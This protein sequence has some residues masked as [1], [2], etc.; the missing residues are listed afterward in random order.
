MAAQTPPLSELLLQHRP[1]HALPQPFYND[2]AIFEADLEAF[3]YRDWL[4]AFPACLLEKTGSYQRLKIGAYDVIVLRDGKGEI[5]AFHNTCR[6]RGSVIC[7]AAQGRV[8]KLTCP[9]HQWTY[10]LDGRLLWARDMGPDFDPSKHG[11]KPVHCR[12]M[13]GLVYICL[14]DEAPDFDTFAETV[15][16]Y[17][18]V[19][20]LS[21]AKVAHQSTIIEKGNWKLVWENNRE[22]YHCAGNHPDLCR[23]Y[24][25]DPTISGVSQDGVFP[26]T[27]E[28]HFNRLEQAGAPSRFRLSES[29]EFRVARMPLLDGAE[30]YTINGKIAVQKKLGRIPM[31]D[32]GTLLLFHY[33]TT[34]NHFLSDHSITFRV[35]PIGPQETEVQTTW[36]VNKDAVEGV[37]Y[38]LKN[39]TTVWEHTNDEDRRVV[40]DNQQGINSPAYEPGPYSASHEDGVIQ[41]VSWYLDRMRA[42]HLPDAMAAE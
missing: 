6:H 11:L 13:A 41:F 28:K 20:D 39:L 38:D 4:Y 29:G 33:P 9:Y 15:A 35:T 40:E 5:A 2:P 1:G 26:D 27:V 18:A 7:A 21:N 22:C 17:L 31:N 34:W 36:L 37:D 25:E 19:H 42:S 12:T 24:P 10:D 14:A 23:T 30:S 3:F 16:P 32:A 8:A